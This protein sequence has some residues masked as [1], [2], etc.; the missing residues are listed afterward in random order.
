[1]EKDQR[2]S[3][4]LTEAL[5]RQALLRHLVL[6]GLAQG[7]PNG[8]AQACTEQVQTEVD[9]ATVRV[10]PPPSRTCVVVVDT[11]SHECL[12]VLSGVLLIMKWLC[13]PKEVQYF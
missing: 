13:T 4:R 6:L 12:E 11:P 8:L 3:G 10:Y 9:G 7:K 2:G 1:M 5:G